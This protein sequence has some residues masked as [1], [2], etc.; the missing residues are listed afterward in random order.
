MYIDREKAKKVFKEY[1][2]NYNSNDGKI[3]LK[4]DHT[5]RVSNICEE[6]AKELN[7]S[8]EDIDIAYIIGL[9]HDIG[10]FEQIKRYGT[11]VDGK[12]INH[13][14]LGVEILF[15]EGKIREFIKD[16][17]EDELIKQAIEYHNAF[18]LP[19]G[20]SK[21]TEIFAK[22]I[23]D[24]DKTDIFRVN[25]TEPTLDVYGHTEEELCNSKLTKE[26]IESFKR[27]ETV[28]RSLEKTAVD[29]VASHIAFVFGIYY[30]ETIKIIAN[31]G[32]L[33]KLMKFKSK[34]EVTNNQLD[35]LREVVNVYI[36]ERLR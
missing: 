13:A 30:D 25:V 34:I 35:E 33:Y 27:H 14:K 8:K 11:F 36:K 32:Y 2:D 23:R 28:L 4:I 10:R 7:F 1:V 6:I 20:L 31:E 3:K 18:E 26:V 12:S 21:R 9:L 22:L 15:K 5:Y 24:A 19:K 16:E 17:S 29:N